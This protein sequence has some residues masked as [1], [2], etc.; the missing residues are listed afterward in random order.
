MKSEY[1]PMSGTDPNFRLK[2]LSPFPLLQPPT[3]KQ[4]DAVAA[5]EVR[6]V[7]AEAL[8][9]T[10][11]GLLAVYRTLELPG[12]HPLKDAHADRDAAVLAAYGFDAKK[13]F[14]AQLLELNLPVAAIEKQGKKATAPGVPANYP[15]PR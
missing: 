1:S 8:A 15:D 2:R 11:G 5:V 14:I 12:K 9:L 3:A 10:T 4:A 13:D 7:R 6:R